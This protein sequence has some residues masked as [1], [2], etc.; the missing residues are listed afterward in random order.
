MAMKPGKRQ[1]M[2]STIYAYFKSLDPTGTNEKYYRNKFS[3][4]SDKEFEDYFNGFFKDP[5][6]Y[7]Q[8]H[9]IDYEVPLDMD[10]I[11][12]TAEKYNI[13]LFEYVYM[14]H[15]TMDKT[16]VVRTPLPVPVIWLNIKRTQQTVAHKN[17][18]STNL[19]S[20]S[21]LTNQLT[22]QD[23]N[24]RSS[25]LENGMLVAMGLTNTLREINGPRADDMVMKSDM[26]RDIATNG[27][28]R[29][30]DSVSENENK[31]TLNTVNVFLLGMG[32]QSD[33]VTSGLMLKDTL[34]KEL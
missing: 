8:L 6:A 3:G 2:E 20:R 28:Y 30:Q 19:D 7:L 29:L 24:G 17:G 11:K 31:T 16:N 22:G 21:P 18:L 12:R 4:M 9:I 15:I 27:Y 1:K 14:P 26:Q 32:F 13:P 34:K 33:L 23:K 5:K 25:D 10:A